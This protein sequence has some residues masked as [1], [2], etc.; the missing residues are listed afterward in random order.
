MTNQIIPAKGL[1]LSGQC[2]TE[3]H[4]SWCRDLR[5]KIEDYSII[6][7]NNPKDTLPNDNKTAQLLLIYKY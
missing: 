4:S 5:R 7:V 6:F 1:V 2:R 3:V